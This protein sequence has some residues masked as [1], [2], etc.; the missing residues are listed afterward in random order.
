MDALS[1][2]T[3]TWCIRD[4]PVIKVLTTPRQEL[5]EK[6]VRKNK[7]PPSCIAQ[8]HRTNHRKAARLPSQN[9]LLQLESLVQS[10]FHQDT[11]LVAPIAVSKVIC[12]DIIAMHDFL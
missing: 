12:R 9:Y 1:N 8:L 7:K 6:I 10:V 2:T 11:W 4:F 5:Q 3:S